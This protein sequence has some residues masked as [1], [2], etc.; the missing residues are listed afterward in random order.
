VGVGDQFDDGD[1]LD[2]GEFDGAAA[3][4]SAGGGAGD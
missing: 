3:G 1:F 4:T 2:V